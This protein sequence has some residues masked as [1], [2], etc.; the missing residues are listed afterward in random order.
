M[1][2]KQSKKGAMSKL[3]KADGSSFIPGIN[4]VIPCGSQVLVELLTAQEIMGTKLT[5]GESVDVGAPQGYV[6][7]V[8]PTCKAS[9]WGF[10]IGD[11]V[12]LHGK[13]PFAPDV[14]GDREAVLIEPN[15]IRAVLQEDE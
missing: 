4:K 9:D 10:K 8:G 2:Q 1:V 13:G 6:K 11:R 14:G 12:M 15:S 5:V 7:A 3:V